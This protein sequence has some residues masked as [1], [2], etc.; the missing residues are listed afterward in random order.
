M[1][2]AVILAAGKAKRM[3]K[4]KQLLP[5]GQSTILERTIEN[6]VALTNSRRPRAGAAFQVAIRTLFRYLGYPF[7]EQQV[8]DGKPDFILPSK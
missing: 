4:Q 3:S 2:S 8:I 5:L 6:V 1:V 7:Q